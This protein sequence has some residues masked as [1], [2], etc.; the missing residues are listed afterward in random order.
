MESC[1]GRGG[2]A[3]RH[4]ISS[5]EGNDRCLTTRLF[6][7]RVVCVSAYLDTVPLVPRGTGA[8]TVQNGCSPSTKQVSPFMIKPFP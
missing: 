4:L 1:K 2:T 3:P 5:P 7:L 6:R 8:S